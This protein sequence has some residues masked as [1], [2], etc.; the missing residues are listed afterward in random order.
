MPHQHN[1]LF[2]RIAN[3]QVLSEAATRAF[4]GKRRKPGAAA[5]VARL[6]TELLRLERRL[7]DGSWQPGPFVTIELFEPKHRIVSAAPFRDRV[8]HHGLC[9][10]IEPIFESGF[11][12]DSY[13]NGIVLADPVFQA[14]GK[15]RALPTIR[16]LNEALHPIPH[17]S[18]GNHIAGITSSGVFSNSQGHPR[19]F[20]GV[21]VA[22]AVSST[23]DAPVRCRHRRKVPRTEVSRARPR[24]VDA[25]S[26]HDG[27]LL[28]WLK[29]LC[30]RFDQ[31]LNVTLELLSRKGEV[32]ER[33]RD[34]IAGLLL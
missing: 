21:S 10:V 23:P 28:V 32:I 34:L 9:A 14:I 13:A 24:A 16:S 25:A 17:Q 3:F 26:I 8:V 20:A 19:L 6:E 33:R 22:A 18:C 5:F 29:P 31:A 4:L 12:D 11:I 1:D 2:E 30:E 27:H 15:Q 7:L